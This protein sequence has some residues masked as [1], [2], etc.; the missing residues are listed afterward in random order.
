MDYQTDPAAVV[1]DVPALSAGFCDLKA[2]GLDPAFCLRNAW[3]VNEAGCY[4]E[5]AKA[6][7]KA[8]GIC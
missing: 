2:E 5:R 1:A 4:L 8:S 3:Q 7:P 6:V